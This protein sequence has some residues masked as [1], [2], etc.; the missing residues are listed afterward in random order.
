[1]AYLGKIARVKTSMRATVQYLE[2]ESRSEASIHVAGINA[3]ADPSLFMTA[4]RGINA[5]HQVPADRIDARATVV[6]FAADEVDPEDDQACA[7]AFEVVRATAQEAWGD[8]GFPVLLHGQR[9]GDSGLFHVHV[10]LPNVQLDTGRAMRG[11]DHRWERAALILDRQ[12]K[13]A[14]MQHTHEA[15]RERVEKIEQKQPHR[16]ERSAHVTADVQAKKR[17]ERTLPKRVAEAMKQLEEQGA[18]LASLEELD[19]ALA[20]SGLTVRRRGKKLTYSEKRG[21]DGKKPQSTREDRVKLA[22][23]QLYPDTEHHSRA[24]MGM[25]ERTHVRRHAP[26]VTLAELDERFVKE[27]QAQQRQARA[28]E[29]RALEEQAKR[30]QIAREDEE[31]RRMERSMRSSWAPPYRPSTPTHTSRDDGPELG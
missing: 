28:K 1:M 11:D 12:M 27:Q 4:M 18:R 30:T 24:M 23:E 29:R 3:P 14:G 15:M 31:R 7:D 9:D 19:D 16:Y 20:P 2:K 13:A 8:R 10:L 21:Q 26:A 17:G 25:P 22:A 6:S 5:H